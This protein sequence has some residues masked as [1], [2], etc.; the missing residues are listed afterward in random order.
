MINKIHPYFSRLYTQ[1]FGSQ[2]RRNMVSGIV[3]TAVN[4]LMLGI[5]YPIY[6]HLLGY[7]KYGLWLILSVVLTFAQLGMLGLNQ[8]VIKLV[9]EEY[10]FGN[11]HGVQSYVMMALAMLTVMGAIVLLSIIVFKVHIINA[12][13][14]SLD[15]SQIVSRLLP[16]IGILSAY[17]F[18]VQVLNATL[19][20]L[21]RMDISNY[22]QAAGRII[23]VIMST[24]L[25][26]LRG[27]IESLLIGNTIS[28]VAISIICLMFIRK[29]VNFRFFQQ[30]N[31]SWQRLKKLLS[32]GSGI[33]GGSIMVILLDPF[34]KLMLSRY[35]GV[36][37]IP[38]YDIAFRAS[39][40]IRGVIEASLRAIM[41]EV[42]RIGANMTVQTHERIKAINQRALKLIFVLGA[43]LFVALFI[44]AKVLLKIWLQTSFN[45]NI[46][47]AFRIMMIAT[48]FSLL[49][50][51]AYY[52]HMG[53]GRI[54]HCFIA[55]GIQFF[56][57]VAIVIMYAIIAPDLIATHIFY[58]VMLGMGTSTIFLVW[59][60]K[61]IDRKM[62]ASHFVT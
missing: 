16:Y 43:P 49:G 57:N 1:A 24:S 45:N 13:G 47:P 38:I 26:F 8:A 59:Q 32:F 52:I 14:I 42:S 39:M 25:L 50:V 15:N 27:G 29:K 46:P 56:V 21:G 44:F 23:A 11:I 37:S 20:G 33:F 10:G 36:A 18:Q 12:F 62:L 9:A 2:L 54:R 55:M 7:E 3:L 48:F 60:L 34:N 31:W 41:P 30:S 53:C 28:Y 40:Q 35:A 17:V 51:P 5:S 19:S 4:M 58:A 22:I 61:R 6:L